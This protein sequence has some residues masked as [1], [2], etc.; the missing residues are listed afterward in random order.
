MFANFFVFYAG[1]LNSDFH[2]LYLLITSKIL[3][4]SI[5]SYIGKMVD[6]FAGLSHLDCP[7][8]AILTKNCR[9]AG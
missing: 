2:A 7:T 5:F 1:D 3:G 6:L 8:I 9:S 4:E